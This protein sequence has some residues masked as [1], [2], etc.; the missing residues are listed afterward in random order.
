MNGEA[1]AI[2]GGDLVVTAGNDSLS[3]MLEAHTRAV[4]NCAETPTA[5]FIRDPNW[6]FPLDLMRQRIVDAV[7]PDQADFLDAQ[8][9][10]TALMG[11]ALYTNMLNAAVRSL[12]AGEAM[13][14]LTQPLSVTSEINLRVPALLPETYCPDVHERLTLYKRLANCESA[15]ELDGLQEELIDRFGQLPLQGQSLLATHRLRLLVKP[16]CIQK[17]DASADQITLQFGPEF[18][19]LAPVDPVRIIDLIQKNRSY[20]LAG[21]DK[22]SLLRHCPTLN[23]KVAA[24]KDMIRQL[25]Q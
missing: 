5:E 10:T 16:L 24:V 6:Q 23:D 15:D 19:Q 7:G 4:V 11:D 9:L 2:L 14:D 25:S 12:K 17:L 13:P 1:H 8:R 18:A 21:Q 22:I 20:K 3:K